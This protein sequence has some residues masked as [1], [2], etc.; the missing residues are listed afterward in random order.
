M[1]TSTVSVLGND[2]SYSTQRGEHIK[3]YYQTLHN[4]IKGRV[5]NISAT[6]TIIMNQIG[7]GE[8]CTFM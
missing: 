4:Q 2:T 6:F 3:K 1:D 5:W 8:K 7:K